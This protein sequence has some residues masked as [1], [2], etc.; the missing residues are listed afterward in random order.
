MLRK[1]D[2]SKTGF[3]FLKTESRINVVGHTM[4]VIPKRVHERNNE[5]ITE[6]AVYPNRI[7]MYI[8]YSAGMAA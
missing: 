6:V 8:I 3:R 2:F 4:M 7:Y 5:S 1:K